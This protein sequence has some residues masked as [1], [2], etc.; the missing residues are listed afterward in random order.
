M[1]GV[2]PSRLRF[3]MAFKE[4][5]LS[6]GF[7]RQGQARFR[8][9]SRTPCDRTKATHQKILG[10][11]KR[12]LGAIACIQHQRSS[13]APHCIVILFDAKDPIQ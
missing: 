11:W 2:D 12:H 3:G 9:N 8:G 10:S 4:S 5:D 6:V 7:S 1:C 13:L